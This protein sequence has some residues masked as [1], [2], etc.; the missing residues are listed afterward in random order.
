VLLGITGALV[1]IGMAI[2]A[3]YRQAQNQ[4]SPAIVDT[5]RQA[6]QKAV[7]KQLTDV[8]TYQAEVAKLV[9]G[10]DTEA[11][12]FRSAIASGNK[13]AAKS[14]GEAEKTDAAL[15]HITDLTAPAGLAE[16]KENLTN[17]LLAQKTAIA[18]A[19]ANA[20][21]SD[22]L[23]RK[24][25]SDHLTEASG[26]IREGMAGITEAVSSLEKQAAGMPAKRK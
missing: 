12:S 5:S 19:A 16:A 9:S 24:A 22:P 26:Q 21:T 6:S 13:A 18:A 25:V 2:M 15:T 7:L 1:L 23:S 3:P 8:K 17:G 20:Q 4:G 10:A 14:L 11:A